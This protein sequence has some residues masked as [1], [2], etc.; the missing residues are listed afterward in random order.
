M[1]LPVWASRTWLYS[2]KPNLF[3]PTSAPNTGRDSAHSKALLPCPPGLGVPS[4]QFPVQI[5]RAAQDRG[6]SFQ[7][8]PEDSH[9]HRHPHTGFPGSAGTEGAR[10]SPSRSWQSSPKAREPSPPG[11]RGACFAGGSQAFREV[12][13]LQVSRGGRSPGSADRAPHAASLRQTPS[14][15]RR[16]SEPRAGAATV[17]DC[18]AVAHGRWTVPPSGQG[19]G[20]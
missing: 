1:Q 7:C 5:P 12:L 2:T 4:P 10:T 17:A 19:E 11:S 3:P 9:L 15:R 13:E 6:P 14:H 8:G 20:R 18:R 16:L